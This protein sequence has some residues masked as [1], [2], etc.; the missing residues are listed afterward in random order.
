MKIT[1][2][3][4]C[5]F[6]AALVMWYGAAAAGEIPALVRVPVDSVGFA[7]T[8]AQ[9]E[10]VVA[11]SDSMI[12]A[13]LP[14]ADQSRAPDGGPL[15]GAI[16]PHDDYIYAGPF[17][18]TA[19]RDVRAPLVV[20]F[21]VCH[22]AR[23]IGLEGKLVFDDFDAW[24]GPYG[25]MPVSPLRERVIELLPEDI[26]LVSG[27]LHAG[28]HSLESLVPF[29]QYPGFPGAGKDR[30][31]LP[32]LVT[33]QP[34]ELYLRSVEAMA[35]ALS[36]VFAEEGL[37]WGRDVAIVISADC[38]HY[39]DEEWGG[40][41]YAPFG[42]DQAGYERA[43]AQDIDIARTALAGPVTME[44]IRLFRE[45]VE[46]DDLEWPYKVTWCGVYSIPF[47]LGVIERLA[48]LDGRESP[49]GVI[50]GYGTSLGPGP[51]PV[52]QTGLGRTAIN[53]LHHWVGYVSIGYR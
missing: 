46:N 42:A 22:K 47:G 7:L 19:L 18:V 5:A 49:T 26:V 30:R 3:V 15:L 45:R 32:V 14:D 28:E 17:Y 52:E 20:M 2:S 38:V 11:V 6:A 37:E 10:A 8:A 24:K 25:Y 43:V 23:R 21:G 9:V 44:K 13:G 39:G 31:I 27:E 36:R 35:S 48:A 40:R 16:V 41:N 4:V 12:A 34:G 53:T 51:L 33:R 50:L 1:Y 29:L